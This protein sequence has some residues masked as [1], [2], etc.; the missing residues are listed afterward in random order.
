MR[1]PMEM[2]F[3]SEADYIVV[4]DDLERAAD[5]LIA[6]ITAESSRPARQPASRFASYNYAVQVV[7]CW[8]GEALRR[9]AAPHF[10]VTTVKDGEAPHVAA[11]RALNRAFGAAVPAGEWIYGKGV[12]ADF[13][14]PVAVETATSGDTDQIIFVYQYRTAEHFAPPDGWTWTAMPA[15]AVPARE[16]SEP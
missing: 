3:A 1:V 13:V 4:N 7:P 8:G 6:I 15:A 16:R 9:D 11:A 12:E 2:Q 5:T 10:P 14:P